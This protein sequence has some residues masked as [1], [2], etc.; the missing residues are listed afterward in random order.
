MWNAQLSLDT[1]K[2]ISGQA[3]DNHDVIMSALP[4]LYY[5]HASDRLVIDHCRAWTMP[6]NMHM[7]TRYIT[8]RPRIICL[9]RDIKA[10]E[11][12]YI[13]L[14][15]R[16]GRDDFYGSEYEQELFR[17]RAAVQHARSLPARWVHWVEYDDLV[18]SPIDVLDGIYAFLGLKMFQHDLENIVCDFANSESSSG[19]VGLHDVRRSVAFR[20]QKD[21]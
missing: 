3:A 11:R 1:Y 18:T 2:S 7:M 13:D 20:H 8:D 14:F 17:N 16:N 5:S 4:T 10:V 6:A 19:L 9:S 12:S 15:R 21:R